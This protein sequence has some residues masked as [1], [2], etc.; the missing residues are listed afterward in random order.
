M[1]KVQNFSE[2]LEQSLERIGTKVG[3]RMEISGSENAPERE[4]V[5]ESIR[6]IVKEVAPVDPLPAPSPAPVP[7]PS[8][9]EGDG[10][11]PSYLA[12]T[13]IDAS[14]KRKIEQLVHMAFVSGGL[15]KAIREAKKQPFFIEDAFHDALVDKAL[16]EL[17]KR[18]ILKNS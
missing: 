4:I 6:S 5:K 12:R 1:S 9:D 8:D 17:K 14:V 13:K 7:A 10:H 16:P 3:E 11:L 2:H 18:G 15:E